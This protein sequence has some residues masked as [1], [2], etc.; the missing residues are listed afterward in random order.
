MVLTALIL[1]ALPAL[2]FRSLRRF[3]YIIHI[4]IVVCSLWW[5]NIFI[6][7]IKTFSTNAIIYVL[8]VHM[9][10]INFV[11]FFLYGYDKKT[12]ERAGRKWIS[13]NTLH[14]FMFIGGTLGAIAGQNYYQHKTKQIGFRVKFWFLFIVQVS[15]LTLFSVWQFS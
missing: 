13:D 6:P 11:T 9:I 14:L 7:D 3:T 4:I 10:S 1:L 15:A 12:Y 5:L 8:G 2:F